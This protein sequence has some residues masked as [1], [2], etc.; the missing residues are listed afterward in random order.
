MAIGRRR[1]AEPP[2]LGRTAFAAP[3]TGGT[4]ETAEQA[5]AACTEYAHN[6]GFEIRNNTSK[7]LA[8]GVVKPRDKKKADADNQDPVLR[9]T[10]STIKTGCG[11]H[12]RIHRDYSAGA[13]TLKVGRA[14]HEHNHELLTPKQRAVLWREV[15]AG[16]RATLLEFEAANILICEMMA[17]LVTHRRTTV[18]RLGY[19]AR[20]VRNFLVRN[21]QYKIANH[22]LDMLAAFKAE[23]D[24]QTF[25][26]A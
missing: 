5:R 7:K 26:L 13:I 9:R 1:G 22:A 25:R 19:T 24:S 21:R 15:P 20:D 11:A 2:E 17:I 6:V 18:P 12:I 8:S 4:Y 10:R 14:V 3:C 16:N 23:Q